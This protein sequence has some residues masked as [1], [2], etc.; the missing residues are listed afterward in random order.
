MWYLPHSYSLF[1]SS[2]WSFR[3]VAIAIHG[4]SRR[5][6]RLSISRPSWSPSAPIF[7][8]V[9]CFPDIRADG[10]GRAL[11]LLPRDVKKALDL[12]TADPACRAQRRRTRGECGVAGRTLQKHFKRFLGRTSGEVLRD[13][14]LERVRHELL[15]HGRKPASPK[16]RSGGASAI[17]GVS[18]RTYSRRY[19]ETPSATSDAGARRLTARS[20]CPTILRLVSIGR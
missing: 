6:I 14:R 11:P 5:P 1:D 9:G 17:S 3:V 20:H 7:G 13:L 2:A 16:A 15:R 18:R 12:L 10:G 19:G 8:I 4:R